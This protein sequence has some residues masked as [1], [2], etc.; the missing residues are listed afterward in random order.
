MQCYLLFKLRSHSFLWAIKQRVTKNWCC[1]E[2]DFV[3]L[4]SADVYPC[5]GEVGIT[6]SIE[7]CRRSLSLYFWSC[8]LWHILYLKNHLPKCF[9]SFFFFF[10]LNIL[11]GVTAQGPWNRTVHIHFSREV[12]WCRSTS[13]SASLVLF[14]RGITLVCI[15]L[16]Q[17]E[18]KLCVITRWSLA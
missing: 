4:L 15:H 2:L 17:L 14:C 16:E 1:F 18:N 11:G 9:V 13:M 3:F 8:I 10:T 7:E 12:K 6:C 5:F